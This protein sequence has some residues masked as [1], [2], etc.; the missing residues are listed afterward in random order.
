[1]R[2]SASR[3]PIS[4][5]PD[6]AA[7]PGSVQAV[8]FPIIDPDGD[9]ITVTV[10]T[11]RPDL[12]T[13]LTVT[14]GASAGSGLVHAAALTTRYSLRLEVAPGENGIAAVTIA[15]SDGTATASDSF[16]VNIQL[17]L[18]PATGS[19]IGPIAWLAAGLV[20]LGGILSGAGRRRTAGLSRRGSEVPT[21][22]GASAARVSSHRST[23]VVAAGAFRSRDPTRANIAQ[24]GA[25][26]SAWSF[27]HADITS[28]RCVAEAPTDMRSA[29]R[30]SSSVRVNNISPVAFA[31]SIR[32]SVR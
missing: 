12:I 11:D 1:M 26:A 15:G 16:V 30:P 32:S 29:D 17:V 8:P 23:R 19:S 10:S 13:G 22:P 18:L 5:Q 6:I 2:S 9:E 3:P 4:D 20:G 28:V 31:A 25:V 27:A 14:Q 24:P 21:G 7:T